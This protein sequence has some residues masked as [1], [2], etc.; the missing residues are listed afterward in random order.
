MSQSTSF[1]AFFSFSRNSVTQIFLSHITAD[2]EILDVNNKINTTG[3]EPCC[4]DVISYLVIG[5][6]LDQY[7]NRL[8]TLPM[9]R[10]GAQL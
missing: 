3:T 4:W 8:L 10:N 5:S 2:Q 7:G 9:K 1:W 6:L